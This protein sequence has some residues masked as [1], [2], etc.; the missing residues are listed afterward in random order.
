MIGIFSKNDRLTTAFTGALAS[1]EAEPFQEAG[2]Y[3]AVLC[4]DEGAVEALIARTT[5]PVIVIGTPH[6]EAALCLKAPIRLD[7]LTRRL[8]AFLAAREADVA[9]DTDAFSFSAQKR[10]LTDKKAER[11]IAL[12]EKES[13]LLAYLTTKE[14]HTASKEQ[15]LEAVWNYRP[16]TET[17]TVE[18]HIYTLK[19]KIGTNADSLLQNTADGYCLFI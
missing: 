8:A 12:T 4:L 18:S 7:V 1:F 14:E 11:E 9:F 2:T 6:E 10:L 3:D 15:L 16:D 17:H 19:Q 5:A 13:A